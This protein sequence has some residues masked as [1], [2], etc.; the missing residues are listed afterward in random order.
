[1]RNL[2]PVVA[3]I[4]ANGFERVSDEE[5]GQRFRALLEALSANGGPP[6]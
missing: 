6:Q 4:T 1:M 2:F 3:T 5:L